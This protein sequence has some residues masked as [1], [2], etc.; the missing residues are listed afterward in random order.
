[1]VAPNSAAGSFR[2]L[3]ELSWALSSASTRAE[4]GVAADGLVQERGPLGR[5][6]LAGR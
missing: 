3:S 4:R 2:K 6:F 1:M 5:R